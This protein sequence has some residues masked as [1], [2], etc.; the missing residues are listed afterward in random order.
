[1]HVLLT[2]D[3][4][5]AH[6]KSDTGDILIKPD[7]EGARACPVSSLPICLLLGLFSSCHRQ[8]NFAFPKRPLCMARMSLFAQIL[9][10]WEAKC[11]I[12]SNVET[13]QKC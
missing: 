6:F 12:E 1:M 4:R 5:L 2:F 10:A 13:K 8:I 9:E 7:L 3:W 11:D